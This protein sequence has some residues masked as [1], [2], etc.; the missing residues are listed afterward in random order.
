MK[1]EMSSYNN[2][3]P[4]FKRIKNVFPHYNFKDPFGKP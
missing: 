3:K 1:I 2:K 4:I